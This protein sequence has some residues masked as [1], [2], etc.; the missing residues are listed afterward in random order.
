LIGRIAGAYR[1]AFAGLPAPV[2]SL[3]L[4][5]FVNRSGTMVVPFLIL[6]LTEARGYS[7]TGA[8]RLLGLYGLGSLAGSYLGGWLSD[9]I[10]PRRVLLLSLSLGGIVFLILGPLRSGTAIAVALLALS[11]I[12]DAF[13][14]ALATAVAECTAP[15]ERS[16]AF[17]L[18]RLAV[19]LGMS[20]GPVAGGFLALYGYS[21]LFVADGTT[22]LLAAGVL[23]FAFRGEP[24]KAAPHEK[25]RDA[26]SSPW[27]DRP[28]LFLA[29]LMTLYALVFFQ[30]LGAFPLTLR[31]RFGMAENWIGLSLSVNTILIVLFEMLLVHSLRR[32]N[33]Y[34]V[35]ACGSLLMCLGFALLPLGSGRAF[36]VFT[37][38][39]WT[40]GEM[41]SLSIVSGL[42]AE[43]AGER[44]Q[45][46]Y[47]GILSLSF[48]VAFV[49]APL[50]GTWIY[51]RFSPEALWY[52]CGVLGVALWAGFMLL[53]G[54][55]AD[56]TARAEAAG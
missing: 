53:A 13:R 3:A 48:S 41:L 56:E 36:V 4:V 31:D 25:T 55:A 12:T 52:G 37:V 38:V 9:H 17:A 24:P 27:K 28:F 16:R 20:V 29:F 43:R 46:R 32:V 44:S 45:G 2:W 50:G 34:R 30:L 15:G 47:M 11:T 14:P 1:R 5:A 33:P 39:I 10:P 7:A 23:A 6:Y 49:L 8:G 26:V 40:L 18:S 22:A 51:Q 35:I 42:V 19:N 21:W 54:V